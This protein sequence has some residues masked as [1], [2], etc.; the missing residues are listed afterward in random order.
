MAFLYDFFKFKNYLFLLCKRYY[1]R[2]SFIPTVEHAVLCHL[3]QD[4]L[5]VRN[6]SHKE[7]LESTGQ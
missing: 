6:L 3:V 4:F 2:H 7:K 1:I 5:I